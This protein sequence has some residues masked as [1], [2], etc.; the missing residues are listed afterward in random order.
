MTGL[1]AA[2][3]EMLPPR[4]C[5]DS[6]SRPSRS[7]G[8]LLTFQHPVRYAV[9]WALQQQC[10][11][12]RRSG[13]RA[14]TLL[15]LEH[16]PVYTAGRGTRPA[17]LKPQGASLHNAA[18]P[19]EV[20]NRG[21]S[22]TYH[23]PGQLVAYPV[24]ALARYAP[25][26]KAYVHMLEDVLIR[27]LLHWDVRG[28]RLP[29]TPGLWVRDGR[30]EAKIASIGARIDRGI[31]MHGFALNV[32][33]DLRPFSRIVPCGL[34]GCRMTSLAEITAAPMSVSAVA[35]HLAEEFSAVFRVEWTMRVVDGLEM[36]AEN[37]QSAAGTAGR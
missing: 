9:A 3:G 1:Q 23:G 37:L 17:H 14:D 33:N 15:L 26:A 16:L 7:S 29:K 30:G 5:D 19:V 27:T 12:E 8:V 25:G 34:D 18:V 10:H 35:E 6:A 31:T 36:T 28:Y 2:V 21:G 32:M 11:A 24:L 20:V 22:V 13:S 4:S